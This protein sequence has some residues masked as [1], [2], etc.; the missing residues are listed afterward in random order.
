MK[1]RVLVTGAGGFVGR[2][3]CAALAALPEVEVL[4]YDVENTAEDL[5]RF[6]EQ[7]TF[8]FHFAAVMRPT[9][10]GEFV[11]V[12]ADLT[13]RVLALLRATERR[14]PVLLTSSIQADL[15]NPYGHSKRMAEEAVFAYGRETE[16]P[17]YVYRMTN[18]FGKWARPNYSSVVATWCH[19]IAHD[20]P[21]YVRAPDA[22]LTLAYIDDV[23][24]EF[25]AAWRGERE[26]VPVGVRGIAVTHTRTLG[27]I[28]QAL[29]RFKTEG[30]RREVPSLHDAFEERL[31]RTYL[32][33]CDC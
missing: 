17:V 8:V 14:I 28:A 19:N 16:T 29:Q 27:Q 1:K 15:D 9:D 13:F 12:N 20:L 21:I 23:V 33:Y 2:N 26:Q 25:L 7:A 18:V 22:Q 32:S 24:G 30:D 31:Y 11:T 4:Q 10:P 6:A 3:V 5:K